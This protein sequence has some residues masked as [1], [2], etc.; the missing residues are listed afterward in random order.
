MGLDIYITRHRKAKTHPKDCTGRT[1][2]DSVGYFRKVNFL[3]AWYEGKYGELPNC[4]E[5]L[6]YR[7]DIESLVKDCLAVMNAHEKCGKIETE[8][9]QTNCIKVEDGANLFEVVSGA[10][11]SEA[12]R[13]NQP[14]DIESDMEDYL[15]GRPDVQLA[16]E[17]LPTMD[18][19]FYGD[20]SYNEYYFDDVKRVWSTFTTILDDMQDGDDIYIEQ[21]Y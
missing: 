6:I 18:G 16:Q 3:I 4:V 13:A 21:S 19:F 14:K 9:R 2:V 17:L 11:R 10:I 5:R 7:E 8:T 12:E 15:N 1:Y 20:T